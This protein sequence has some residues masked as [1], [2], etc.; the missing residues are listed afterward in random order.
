M[1]RTEIEHGTITS[2]Q[3]AETQ[4]F[5]DSLTQWCVPAL[6]FLF[7][8][9]SLCLLRGIKVPS[10]LRILHKADVL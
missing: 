4:D 3:V 1:S 5:F 6:T 8:C 9:V 7:L 2:M 10:T